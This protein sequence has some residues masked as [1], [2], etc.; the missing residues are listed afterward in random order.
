M[1][2]IAHF[3]SFWK[4]SFAMVRPMRIDASN[5]LVAAQAQT[6]RATI[7]AKGAQPQFE[8]LDFVKSSGVREGA[9]TTQAA[10]I[11]RPGAQLDIKV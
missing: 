8:P 3:F 11:P 6:Q 4:P 10:G 9:Q 7:A 1:E 2:L 5:L